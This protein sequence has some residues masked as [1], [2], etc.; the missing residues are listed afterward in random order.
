MVGAGSKQ[1][2]SPAFR[3]VALLGPLVHL[4]T[5]FSFWYA[6]H[7][8]AV[9]QRFSAP[10]FMMSCPR[11]KADS[12]Q[13]EHEIHRG[14]HILIWLW[15]DSCRTCITNLTLTFGRNLAGCRHA[16]SIIISCWWLDSQCLSLFCPC[17]LV[18]CHFNMVQSRLKS[19]Q[20]SFGWAWSCNIPELGPES[21]WASSRT[22]PPTMVNSWSWEVHW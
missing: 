9:F 20:R 19:D 14:F 11:Q 21:N 2:S 6:D 3:Q 1:G 10:G 16:F 7:V 13:L 4:A 8:L 15:V 17:F 12:I 18:C 22:A 5:I